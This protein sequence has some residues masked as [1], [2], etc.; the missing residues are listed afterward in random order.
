MEISTVR[1]EKMA[2]YK[3][4]PVYG[5]TA[6]AMSAG[7]D[8]LTVV[9][10][11]LEAGIRCVQYREKTKSGLARYEECLQLRQLTRKYNALLIIDD[12]VDLAIAVD[13]DGVHVGQDD[14]PPQVVRKLLGNDKIIGLST[15]NP[16]QLEQANMIKDIIDYIGTGPVYATQTKPG[17]KAAGLDYI[18]CASEHS[19]LPFV[20]IG[21]LK[22]HN[23]AE[24]AKR[25]AS[26]IAV[27]S[28]ITGAA[29]IQK[30]IQEIV[31]NFQTS[32]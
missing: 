19:Q 12:F 9:R 7:R 32:R 2:I 28:E 13:A 3:S 27:V 10:E 1:Q 8:N 23:V 30:K 16:Q 26:C 29:D 4:F 22:A 5:I 21:G 11:M 17:A 24:V 18:S 14:L 31:K 6:E 15:H 20:A 25:G